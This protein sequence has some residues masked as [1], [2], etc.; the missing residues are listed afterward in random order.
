MPGV[1]DDLDR[2]DFLTY[3]GLGSGS[4]I[5]GGVPVDPAFARRRRRRRTP[6]AREGTFSHGVAS[7]TPSQNAIRLWTRLGGYRR[8]RKLWLEVAKDPDFRRVVMRRPARARSSRDH[9]V[10]THVKGKFLRPDREYYYRFE[11]RNES[12][13][14]GRFRTL[15]PRDSR[16]PIRIGF[17]SCQDYQAGYYGAHRALADEDLD[18]VICLGDYIYERT[19][20]DGPADRKDRLG[21]NRDGEVQTLREYRQK[22]KLYRADRDLQAMHA[23]HPFLAIWDDHEVEDNYA[24]NRPGHATAQRRVPF[25]RRRRNG[26]RAFYE[27]M[28]FSP[29]WRQ[30]LFR[31]LRLGRNVELFLLDQRG[32]RDAQ[33]C[34]DQFFVPCPEAESRPRDYLGPGQL[35]WLKGGLSDSK[36]AWKLIGN[37]A[38]IMALDTAAKQPIN[39]DQWDGYGV[40]RRDLLGHIRSRGIE[41]VS[42][43]TGDIHTFFAGDVGVNGRGPGSVATEF[44][45]GSVTSLGI[46]ESVQGATGVPLT[47]EQ[48]LLVTRN[49][50][51]VNPHIKYDEQRSR[52]Y[53]VVEAKPDELRVDFRAVRSV[54]RTT[55]ARTIARFRVASGVPRV[56]R[57]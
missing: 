43:L 41:N 29:V 38:M 2:R 31:Q 28:P 27:Y 19:F 51:T 17:F 7:G 23:A 44:V 35:D 22:Y 47:K 55:S 26:Y 48:L 49:V 14:V 6:F 45:G 20:Y 12:S 11:T 25:A 10:E 39:K 24:D 18:L 9:T 3:A 5:L 4:L 46:P 37:Q 53:A 21:A 57:L 30:G 34:D 42:F 16:Q 15:P 56:Q 36:A 52:G 32:F 33:P 40:E 54:P 50:R 1:N 13:P 8:D